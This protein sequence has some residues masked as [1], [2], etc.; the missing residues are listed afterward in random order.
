MEAKPSRSAPSELQ[1]ELRG[2]LLE[3]QSTEPNAE[4]ILFVLNRDV[5]VDRKAPGHDSAART[6]S[7]IS[8]AV[9]QTQ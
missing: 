4:G 9:S 6:P 7:V 2:G 1:V 3:K 8:C 5:S